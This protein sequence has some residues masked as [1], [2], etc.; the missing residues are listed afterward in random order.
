VAARQGAQAARETQTGRRPPAS[1]L[2]AAEVPLGRARWTQGRHIRRSAGAGTR[3]PSWRCARPG[4]RR[5]ATCMDDLD[6]TGQGSPR[7]HA[8]PRRGSSVDLLSERS[9]VFSTRK[10][11]AGDSNAG[12][13]H[14]HGSCTARSF[15][16][17]LS[18]D[19]HNCTSRNS[20]PQTLLSRRTHRTRHP[21]TPTP[22]PYA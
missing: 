15:C 20:W 9:T 21:D 10:R 16:Q 5:L 1:R 17:H 7:T 13:R 11:A 22:R 4:A 3:S 14:P 6:G 2:P 19:E 18:C 12:A 8:A